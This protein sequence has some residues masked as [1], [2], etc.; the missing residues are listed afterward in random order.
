[1][2]GT[3][4]FSGL[5]NPLVSGQLAWDLG[6]WGFSYLLGA[7]IYKSPMAWSDTS[8]NQRF[9]L[10]YTRNDWNKAAC[11][12]AQPCSFALATES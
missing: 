10:S 6:G 7:Y 9:A 11:W 1:M 3:T 5:Y 12:H 4:Y 8:L 2:H